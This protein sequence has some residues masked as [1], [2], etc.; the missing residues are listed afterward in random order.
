MYQ[1]QNAN[2]TTTTTTNVLC[3]MEDHLHN[4]N[5]TINMQHNQKCLSSNPEL[6]AHNEHDRTSP[7]QQQTQTNS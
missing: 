6:D 4:N 3:N 5:N 1:Q 7:Q 2:A